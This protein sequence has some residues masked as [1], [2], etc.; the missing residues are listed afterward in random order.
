MLCDLNLPERSSIFFG[1]MKASTVTA[2]S[3]DNS[4]EVD[5]L[6]HVKTQYETFF[7]NLK[8]TLLQLTPKMNSC[9]RLY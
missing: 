7:L 1:A 8:T 3:S 5:Y 9:P 6:N 2:G 4:L